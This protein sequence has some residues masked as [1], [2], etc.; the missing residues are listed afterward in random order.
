MQNQQEIHTLEAQEGQ[1]DR[2]FV[3][4]CTTGLCALYVHICVYHLQRESSTT[5]PLNLSIKVFCFVLFRAVYS[6]DLEKRTVG[7]G[8][9]C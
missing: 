7:F 6:I 2:L 1:K 3:S 4:F 8:Q 5:L 9:A